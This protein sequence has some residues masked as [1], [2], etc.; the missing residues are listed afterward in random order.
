ME[1]TRIA[2]LTTADKVEKV[3]SKW[4]TEMDK[5]YKNTPNRNDAVFWIESPGD[6]MIPFDYELYDIWA[7]FD[8]GSPSGYSRIKDWVKWRNK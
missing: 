7:D 5:I 6:W 3:F 8:G 2:T 4:S 1:K